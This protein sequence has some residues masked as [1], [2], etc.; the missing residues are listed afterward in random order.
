MRC[1]GR[2]N[3]IRRKTRHALWI[4]SIKQSGLTIDSH[5]FIFIAGVVWNRW[6]ASPKSMQDAVLRVAQASRT[7]L[8][9]VRQLFDQASPHGLPGEELFVDHV[10]PTFRGHQL[11]AEALCQEMVRQGMLAPRPGYEPA[12][13]AL[14]GQQFQSLPVSYFER[15]KQR[16]QGLQRWTEGR[17]KK[18]RP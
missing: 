17:A 2:R 11:I 6:G 12:R 1:G 15:G 9:D 5:R 4:R 8:V 7:P 10:H 14:Y 3:W 16:L 13:D 18:V